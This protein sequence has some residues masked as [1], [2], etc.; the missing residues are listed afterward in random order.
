[1]A[2]QSDDGSLDT[3][4]N[5]TGKATT[6]FADRSAGVRCVALQSDGKIVE[7]GAANTNANAKGVQS[8]SPGLPSCEATLGGIQ[9]RRQL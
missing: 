5:G 6:R 2:L 9:N 8:L 3:S 1:M 7:A 4:F